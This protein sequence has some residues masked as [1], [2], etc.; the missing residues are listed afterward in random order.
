MHV[1]CSILIV[2]YEG[3]MPSTIRADVKGLVLAQTA[4][5]YKVDFREGLITRHSLFDNMH[6]YS[7]VATLKTS[8][9]KIEH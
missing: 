3:W 1:I 8:C 7:R 5:H 6:F 4:T 9:T 2:V